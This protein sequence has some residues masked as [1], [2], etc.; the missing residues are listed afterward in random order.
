MILAY[1]QVV[2]EYLFFSE[3]A[4]G[5]GKTEFP[6]QFT[7]LQPHFYVKYKRWKYNQQLLCAAYSHKH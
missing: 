2:T 6:S 1:E 7:Y 3:S 5:A 4:N